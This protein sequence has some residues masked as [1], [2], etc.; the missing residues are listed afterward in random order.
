[1]DI[2]SKILRFLISMNSGAG[3]RATAGIFQRLPDSVGQVLTAAYFKG[4][5]IP[6][7]YGILVFRGQYTT[8]HLIQFCC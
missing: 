8:W 5:P 6:F 1:M 3:A 7:P 2:N 4:L